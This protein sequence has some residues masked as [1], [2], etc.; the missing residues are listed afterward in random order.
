MPAP[1]F[2]ICPGSHDC[3]MGLAPTRDV[4]RRISAAIGPGGRNLSW[5]ISGCAN[6][7][8]QPQLAN[9]GIL[10]ARFT[11]SAEGDKEPLFTLLRRTGPGLGTKVAEGL[12]LEAL[13]ERI[14]VLS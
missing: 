14:A 7:C 9:V 13:L 1:V 11:S 10:T 5:A 4:A 12:S 2:R 8:S 3:R 6:S